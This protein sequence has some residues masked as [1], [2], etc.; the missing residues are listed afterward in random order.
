MDALEAEVTERGVRDALKELPEGLDATYNRALD[1]IGNMRKG[2]MKL[3]EKVLMWVSYSQR[4]FQVKELQEAVAV[5]PNETK[6]DETNIPATELLTSVCAGLILVDPENTT[7]RF[8]HVTTDIFFQQVRATR[9]P[10]AET[11]LAQ[12]CITYLSYFR[13]GPAGYMCDCGYYRQFANTPFLEYAGQYWGDHVRGKPES[14]L[15]GSILAF[16]RNEKL[17]ANCVEAAIICGRFA[18][19]DSGITVKQI[20]DGPYVEVCQLSA[21]TLWVAASFGLKETVEVLLREGADPEAVDALYSLTALQQASLQGQEAVVQVLLDNGVAVDNRQDGC[22]TALF[23][24]A[25]RGH[26]E[27][28]RLL[29]NMGADPNIKIPRSATKY[30]RTTRS[31]MFSAGTPLL[32]AIRGGHAAVTALLIDRGA[33][34]AVKFPN[35][36]AAMPNATGGK[37]IGDFKR[38]KKGRKQQSRTSARSKPT[39]TTTQATDV[40]AKVWVEVNPDI[41]EFLFMESAV[42]EAIES[43]HTA[44]LHVLV[45]KGLNVNCQMQ[46]G[47]ALEL[48]I[49]SGNEALTTFLLSKGAVIPPMALL[50]AVRDEPA[51]DIVRALLAKGADPHAKD[52][53]GKSAFALAAAEGNLDIVKILYEEAHYGITVHEDMEDLLEEAC[54]RHSNHN[55]VK[56]LLDTIVDPEVR[57][58]AATNALW[59]AAYDGNESTLQTLLDNGAEASQEFGALETAIE[60]NHTAIVHQ[61]LENGA[62]P[63]KRDVLTSAAEGGQVAMLKD[64]LDHG[65]DP[66]T[67]K[68]ESGESALLQAVKKGYASIV[69]ILLQANAD[70]S[71]E[72]RG[73]DSALTLV[74]EGQDETINKLLKE[75]RDAYEVGIIIYCQIPKL[76]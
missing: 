46:D 67:Q 53:R 39:A 6:P 47:T 34:V 10:E 37:P 56:F 24:A 22:P 15:K 1:R 30:R 21:T 18:P 16:L 45:E 3:A 7:V 28:V 4:P 72:D 43:E 75:V 57:R 63:N 11:Y 5:I 68:S 59:S 27:V 58:D 49:A 61:L 76:L 73:G 48:A 25:G 17:V 13:G 40:S 55:I 26:T 31:S 14:E 23:L 12:T 35:T 65:A 29:L 20:D 41:E 71:L 9:F 70:P 74:D 62:N 32:S 50:L 54:G 52:R 2:E 19:G 42:E 8:V 44:V 51:G 69:Q 60:H 38:K 36:W 66:N 33:H 64:L